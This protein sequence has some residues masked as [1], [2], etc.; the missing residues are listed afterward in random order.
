MSSE[1]HRRRHD[2]YDY[3]RDQRETGR[4]QEDRRD[5]GRHEGVRREDDRRQEDRRQEE[6]RDAE[7]RDEERRV[8]DRREAERRDA[9]RRLMAKPQ[10]QPS[11][12]TSYMSFIPSLNSVDMVFYISLIVFFILAGMSI[13]GF[14]SL[15][16]TIEVED[17][18]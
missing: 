5:G 7:R 11:S 16:S 6:R 3:Q 2:D 1:Q 9:E 13:Y 17:S 4:R 18:E 10:T 14:V 12:L 15:N 8:A